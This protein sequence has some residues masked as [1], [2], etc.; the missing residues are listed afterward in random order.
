MNKDK[1]P[2]EKPNTEEK[3]AGNSYAELTGSV[4]ES[5]ALAFDAF[6]RRDEEAHDGES[7]RSAF[8]VQE[9]W[10]NLQKELIAW[11]EREQNASR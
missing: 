1:T 6:K 7:I 4:P 9:A 11:V 3:A 8:K 10:S 5:F 2:S